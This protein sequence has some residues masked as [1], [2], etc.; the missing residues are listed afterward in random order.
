M[1]F[2]IGVVPVKNQHSYCNAII[3][4]ARQTS[5]QSHRNTSSHRERKRTATLAQTRATKVLE[6]AINEGRLQLYYQPIES[7][8]P[9]TEAIR[10][11]LFVRM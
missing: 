11:E 2:H 9:D 5:V 10:Y 6:T 7:L 3:D 8:G 4:E 1:N